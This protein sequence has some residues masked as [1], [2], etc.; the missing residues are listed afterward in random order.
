MYFKR[1][2]VLIFIFIVNGALL[3]QTNKK[4]TLSECVAYVL[5][6]NITIKQ[7]ELDLKTTDIEKLEAIGNFLPG[8][9][10]TANYAINTG[11]NINPATNQFENETFRSASG[12]INSGVALFNGLANW[13]NLQRSKLSKMAATFRLDKMKDDIMLNVANNYLQILLAKEQVKILNAQNKITQA[14]INQTKDLID[15]GSLPAGDLYELLANDASQKQQIIAAENQLFLSKLA[16]AQIMLLK[17]YYQFDIADEGF[18]VPLTAIYNETPENIAKK[19]RE[20]VNDIKVAQGAL[21]IAKK[22]LEVAR[23][24]YY[25]NLSAFAGYNTRWA[26]SIPFPF[27]QQVYL[28]DG[29]TLGFQLSVPVLNGFATRGRVQRAK[30]NIERNEYLLQQADLD[31]EQTIYQAYNDLI[32]A[33]KGFEAATA[34]EEARKL[35]FDFSRERFNVGLLNSLDFNQSSMLFENALT[36]TVRAKYDLIFR[37]KVLEFYFGLPITEKP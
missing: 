1:T 27:N 18:D 13:K 3:A 16:L 4:W 2:S 14:N 21:D 34:T 6:N 15:A 30:I 24:G 10:A 5:E 12:N 8:L 37:I 7:S 31:L 26:Q 19:A 22:D 11:A 32:A 36:E 33:K 9:Q 23:S 28:F 17:E 20:T 29:T 25:P 35:A